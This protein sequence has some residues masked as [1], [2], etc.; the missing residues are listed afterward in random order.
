MLNGAD[1]QFSTTFMFTTGRVVLFLIAF[2]LVLPDVQWYYLETGLQIYNG[3]QT[4]S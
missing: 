1:V 4:K 3:H 2:V